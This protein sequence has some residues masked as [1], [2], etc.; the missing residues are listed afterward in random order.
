MTSVNLRRLIR[1][2]LIELVVYAG[3]LV[4]YFFL[5]LRVL[6]EP[7][8]SLYV[9]DLRLYALAALGL[10]VAQAVLLELLTSFLMDRLGLERPD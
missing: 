5:V 2:L 10:I 4:A 3:L 6:G 8:E 1:N 7:L 9:A